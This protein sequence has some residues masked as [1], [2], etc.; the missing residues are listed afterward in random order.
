MVITLPHTDL[1]PL[2]AKPWLQEFTYVT[3]SIAIEIKTKNKIVK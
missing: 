1:K 3:P 2:G